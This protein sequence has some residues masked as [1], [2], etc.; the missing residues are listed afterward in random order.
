MKCVPHL[1]VIAAL[2]FMAL[3]P[4]HSKILPYEGSFGKWVTNG[5]S[6]QI[7]KVFHPGDS[8]IYRDEDVTTV[9]I[10][11]S[12]ISDLEK[13]IHNLK[14]CDKFYDCVA[15]RDGYV[16]SD[17]HRPEHCYEPRGWKK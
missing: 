14:L 1:T 12:E 15:K 10:Q 13:A 6:C 2:V 7:I 16:K 8:N 17:G 11:P 4:A 5:H 9:Y 3:R